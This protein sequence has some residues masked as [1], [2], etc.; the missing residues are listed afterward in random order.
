MKSSTYEENAM[1]IRNLFA[2]FAIAL[3]MIAPAAWAGMPD[4]IRDGAF[5]EMEGN[6]VAD[7]L[8]MAMD[9]EVRNAVVGDAVVKGII[10][11]FD[12]AART[13]VIGGVN[14]VAADDALV[15]TDE[16]LPME[17]SEFIVGRRGKAEGTWDNGIITA[18]R[19]KLKR[20]K[21]GRENEIDLSGTAM[22]VNRKGESFML[23]GIE[24]LITPTTV[25]EVQ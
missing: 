23:L 9:V 20:I 12:P 4:D 10:S 1:K 22:N 2:S 11:E 18:S 25:V 13:L 21:P 8:V 3:L 17:F 19:V 16:N 14:V 6:L 5:I 7:K 24:V 15:Q